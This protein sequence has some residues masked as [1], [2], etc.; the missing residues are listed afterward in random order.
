MLYAMASAINISVNGLDGEVVARN[1]GLRGPTINNDLALVRVS[2]VSSLT[3]SIFLSSPK[4]DRGD[5][6]LCNNAPAP[7]LV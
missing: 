3:T 1:S 6:Y 7:K 5:L 2:P 4:E